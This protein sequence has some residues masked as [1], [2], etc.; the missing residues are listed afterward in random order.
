MS[1]ANTACMGLNI[2][3]VV[4]RGLESMVSISEMSE[5]WSFSAVDQCRSHSVGW[6]RC[7]YPPC[8]KLMGMKL[9]ALR[10]R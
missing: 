3:W 7:S 6:K 2:P 5:P 8:R 1:L 10:V 4:V 9:E